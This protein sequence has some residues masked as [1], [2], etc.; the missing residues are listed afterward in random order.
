MATQD[1]SQ[2]DNTHAVGDIDDGL[3]QHVGHP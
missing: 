3:P 1:L 2:P